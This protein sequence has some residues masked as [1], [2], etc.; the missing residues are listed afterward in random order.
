MVEPKADV[1][2][3]MSVIYR[4]SDKVFLTLKLLA[5]YI[6]LLPHNFIVPYCTLLYPIHNYLSVTTIYLAMADGGNTPSSP[7]R[8]RIIEFSSS[9]P[10]DRSEAGTPRQPNLPTFEDESNIL[11]RDVEEEEEVSLLI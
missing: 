11:G 4:Q 8:R 2:D 9:P 7:G 1:V 6:I 10:R 3:V 5:V